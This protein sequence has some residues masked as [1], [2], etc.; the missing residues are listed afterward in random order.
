MRG[1]SG[2]GWLT[3]PR[4]LSVKEPSFFLLSHLFAKLSDKLTSSLL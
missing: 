1:F 3:A 2:C 4:M